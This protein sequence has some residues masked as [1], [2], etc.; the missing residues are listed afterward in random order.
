MKK[1]GSISCNLE[2]EKVNDIILGGEQSV[3][4]PLE[5]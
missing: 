5:E 3:N 4:N 1:T 2:E